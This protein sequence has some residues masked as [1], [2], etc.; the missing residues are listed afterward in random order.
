MKVLKECHSWL[1]DSDRKQKSCYDSR[2]TERLM[3]TN[4]MCIKQTRPFVLLQLQ[5]CL[6][7]K[8][9]SGRQRDSRE[10]KGGPCRPDASTPIRQVAIISCEW[11]SVTK[12]EEDPLLSGEPDEGYPEGS[13]IMAPRIIHQSKSGV[14]FVGFVL[15]SMKGSDSSPSTMS[16]R[17][18]M[19]LP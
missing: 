9:S 16:T 19:G 3:M 15:R 14:E 4:P 17:A 7:V 18:V 5:K 1:I 12:A 13:P 8:H 6:C 2:E 10:A 11:L